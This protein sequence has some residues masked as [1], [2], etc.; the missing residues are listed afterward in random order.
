MAIEKGNIEL[1]PGAIA[2]VARG[3]WHVACEKLSEA[4]AG[5]KHM[6]E[7]KN[8]IEYEAG[9]TRLVDS[10]EEFW[11]RFFDEGKS[12][13]SSFQPWAGAIAR[14]RTADPLL[15]Y[16]FQARH[17][18]QHGR[19][20]L[21]WD[22]GKVEIGGGEFF[23][24]IKDLRI[25]AEGAFEADVNPTAGSGAKFKVIL[26]P[27]NARLPVVFNKKFKQSYDPP[28]SHLDKPIA[29]ASPITVGRLG[30]A[31]YDDLLR[32]AFEKFA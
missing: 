3:L 32:Q 27:G 29:D 11:T 12:K 28:R 4:A 23:G 15:T 10:L 30:V 6:E 25:A 24:T 9:W 7:A 21:E 13:F 26:N 5:V 19:I 16:L 14:K 8:R 1:L 31:F 18:S 17:Q 2:P 20:A 22:R